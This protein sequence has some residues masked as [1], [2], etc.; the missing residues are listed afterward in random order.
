MKK[1]EKIENFFHHFV[2]KTSKASPR[3]QNKL[4]SICFSLAII[5][6]L[7]HECVKRLNTFNHPLV[8]TQKRKMRELLNQMNGEK[9][10][11]SMEAD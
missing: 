4:P 5:I 10:P 9:E 8:Y 6:S 11:S 1:G 3:H 2:E 7:I